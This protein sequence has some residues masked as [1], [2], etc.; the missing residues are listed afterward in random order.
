MNQQWGHG[1]CFYAL[2]LARLL[3]RREYAGSNNPLVS[4]IQL[5]LL[6]P[7]VLNIFGVI[8]FFKNLMT[9]SDI[10]LRKRLIPTPV[11]LVM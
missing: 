6:R 3:D 5:T 7:V 10:P 1:V 2:T 4:F 8:H 11:I 9:A